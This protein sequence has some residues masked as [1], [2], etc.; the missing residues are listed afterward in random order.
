MTLLGL[1]KGL[2]GH[3]A[4]SAADAEDCC[5]LGEQHAA[6]GQ[7]NKAIECF[8]RAVSLNP[9]YAPAYV[10]LS[11]AYREAGRGVEAVKAC[12]K[13]LRL[14]PNDPDA[15]V[16]LATAYYEMGSYPEALRACDK[17]LHAAPNY[18]G[19]YFIRGL[20]YID[21][22]DRERALRE[23]KAL[24]NFDREMADRLFVKIPKR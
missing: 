7:V 20:S 24:Q 10:N 4:A 1:L 17:A 5:E 18:P 6:S 13:A 12:H 19:A 11:A 22:G 8:E 9:G 3:P 2:R 21:L 14:S 15:H 23:Y 16:N